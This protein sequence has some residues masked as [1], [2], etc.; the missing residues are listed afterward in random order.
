MLLDAVII[1]LREVLEAALIIS[2]LLASNYLN[3]VSQRWIIPALGGGVLLSI[4]LATQIGRISE[5][6]DGTGQEY[7]QCLLLSLTISCLLIHISELLIDHVKHWLGLFR[8]L[9]VGMA[10]ALAICREGE[11]IFIYGYGFASRADS[12]FHIVLGTAIGAGIGISI[13]VLCY[14]SL[15]ALNRKYVVPVLVT[16]LTLMSAGMSMQVVMYLIQ[17]GL[18]DSQFPIWNSESLVAESSM[19]GQLLFALFAYESTPTPYQAGTYLAVIALVFCLA[20]AG[21]FTGHRR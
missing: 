10:V 16:L 7:A 17:A 15:T 20:L 1:V 21:K 8:S 14:Y 5:A 9:P 6:F 12:K 2:T 18:A 19:V 11:E 13:G 4:L 3:G